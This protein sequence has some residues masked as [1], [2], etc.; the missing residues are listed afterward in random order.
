MFGRVVVAGLALLAV[1]GRASA[2]ENCT[3]IHFPP[4]KSSIAVQG[5]APP[6]D[7]PETACYT[8]AAAAGQ[9]ARVSVNNHMVVSVSD[10]GDDRSIWVFKT[11]AQTYK[12]IVA[13]EGRSATR[14]PFT[15]TLSIR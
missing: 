9:T 13:Q 5:V 12:L 14:D 1:A 15:L 8:F 6:S 3:S 4:G 2:Q 11:K 10:V 7:S